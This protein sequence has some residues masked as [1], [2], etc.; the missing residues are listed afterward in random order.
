TD[1]ADC[2]VVEG[3]EILPQLCQISRIC[4]IVKTGYITFLDRLVLCVVFDWVLYEQGD[5]CLMEFFS[6]AVDLLLGCGYSSLPRFQKL[7]GTRIIRVPFLIAR[8]NAGEFSNCGGDIDAG[9]RCW[10]GRICWSACWGRVYLLLVHHKRRRYSYVTQYG[11]PQCATTIKTQHLL[12]G[13]KPHQTL[14][15]AA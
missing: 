13:E 11:C 3:I 7:R 10:R 1:G 6:S 5:Q 9:D 2:Q 8:C 15:I 14:K 12:S 4:I